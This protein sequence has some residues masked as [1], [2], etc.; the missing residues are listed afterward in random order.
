LW[1]V[2]NFTDSFNLARGRRSV[3]RQ[4]LGQSGLSSPIPTYQTDF[5]ASCH[6]KIDL[7]HQRARTDGNFQ[8][9]ND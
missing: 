5:V 4:N 1:Q 3:T 9:L 8:V 2:A 6:A 7:T